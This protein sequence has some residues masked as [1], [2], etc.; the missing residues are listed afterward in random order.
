MLGVRKFTADHCFIFNRLHWQP[1]VSALFAAV[2]RMVHA[3]N[4]QVSSLLMNGMSFEWFGI[5][6]STW[7][8]VGCVSALCLLLIDCEQVEH[9]LDW[10]D[11]LLQRSSR[12][13]SRTAWHASEEW[14][15]GNCIPINDF[16]FKLGSVTQLTFFSC[17]L[18]PNTYQDWSEL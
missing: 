15:Q 14:E 12:Q 17:F 7:W 2:F 4:G 1:I 16:F 5:A 9:C 13:H 11:D 8:L 18:D 3:Y 6:S 10:S